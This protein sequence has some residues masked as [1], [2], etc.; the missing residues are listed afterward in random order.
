MADELEE[1][2]QKVIKSRIVSA[3]ARKKYSVIEI[4][5]LDHERST[6]QNKLVSV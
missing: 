2:S 4:S 1:K 3:G 6:N 5:A